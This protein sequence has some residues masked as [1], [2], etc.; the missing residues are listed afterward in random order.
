MNQQKFTIESTR[1][2]LTNKKQI[3]HTKFT[4]VFEPKTH[5]KVE[6]ASI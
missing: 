3:K 6:I 5:F 2:K 4:L 1:R